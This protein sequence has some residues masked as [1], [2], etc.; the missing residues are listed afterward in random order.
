MSRRPPVLRWLCIVCALLFALTACGSSSKKTSSS[1]TTGKAETS[2][3]AKANSEADKALAAKI[4]LVAGD[5][6]TGWTAKAAAS[7]GASSDAS[8]K[9]LADCL[10]VPAPK[11][12][13]SATVDSPDFSMGEITTAS[14]SV[15]VFKN[16]GDA[17]N[18][19]GKGRLPKF[20]DCVK[21]QLSDAISKEAAG[22]TVGNVT[23]ERKA[24]PKFGDE[25]LAYHLTMPLEALGQK[26]PLSFDFVV[27]RKGR[28]AASLNF[29][30][31]PDAFDAA[32][33]STLIGK[34]GQRLEANA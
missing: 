4:N 21:K 33:E 17:K 15:N 7:S 9:E 19:I 6:P 27:I 28:V 12:I 34:V 25:A 31:S 26:I 2:T 16:S 32:L 11:T 5:L 20:S 22:A 8:E 1:A 30:S 10:G 23:L 3:T 29:V 24:D 14:S 18:D 13:D